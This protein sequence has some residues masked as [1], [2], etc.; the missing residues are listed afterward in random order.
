VA[1]RHL[2]GRPCWRSAESREE[3]YGQ[4]VLQIGGGV[5]SA[6]CSPYSWLVAVC[7]WCGK[8]SPAQEAPVT[9]TFATERERLVYFCEAC[10]R[11]NLRAMEGKLDSEYW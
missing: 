5:R 2:Q 4:D 3:R 7:S 6:T 8:V 11:E 9:W 10:S 1:N